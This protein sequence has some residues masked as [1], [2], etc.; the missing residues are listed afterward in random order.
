MALAQSSSISVFDDSSGTGTGSRSGTGSFASQSSMSAYLE[1]D[2][3]GDILG[4]DEELM[5]R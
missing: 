2:D 3:E 1:S 5:K 4:E